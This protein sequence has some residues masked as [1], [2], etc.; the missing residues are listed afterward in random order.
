[1]A[2]GIDLAGPPCGTFEDEKG[3]PAGVEVI[4]DAV[5]GRR[6]AAGHYCDSLTGADSI[7]PGAR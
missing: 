2:A 6:L 1:M 3:T 5:A 7:C 4:R